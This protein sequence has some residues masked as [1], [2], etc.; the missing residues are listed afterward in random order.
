MAWWSWGTWPD[1]QVDF[2]R[3]LY[4]PWRLAEGDV[5][6]R[7]VAWFNGPLSVYCNAFLFRLFGAGLDTL[8]F[9]NLALLA[10]GVWL[11]HRLVARIAD[12]TTATL[13]CLVALLVFAFNQLSGISNYN[14]VTPYSHE[15]THGVLLGLGTLAALAAFER[16]AGV[17][18]SAATG[19]LAGLTLLTKPEIAAA[20]ALSVAAGWLFLPGP[21]RR[22]G[23]PW[24][25]LGAA[26]PPLAALAL[27][28]LALPPGAALAGLLEGWRGVLAGEAPDLLFYRQLAGFDA[29][30]QRLGSM[31][32]TAL[33]ALGVLLPAA[34]LDLLLRR[35][36]A[37]ST[38]A[39]LLV[40]VGTLAAVG[41]LPVDWL[42][43]LGPLPLVLAALLCGFAWLRF[44]RGESAPPAAARAAFTALG[45]A[46][47]AKLLLTAWA[48]GYGFALALPG[49]AVLLVA[50]FWLAPRAL[51]RYGGSGRVFRAA[52]LALLCLW[53][54]AHLLESHRWLAAN[55]VRVADGRDAF[56]SDWRGEYANAVI[57]A[58]AEHFPA[59]A[60]LVVLPE[61]VMLNYLT[62]RANPTPYLNFM[63][64]EL[65]LFGEAEIIAALDANPPD[66]VILWHKDTREY[67][68]PLFGR[69]Y[70]RALYAWVAARYQPIGTFGAI[71]LRDPDVY[72]MQLLGPRSPATPEG[73]PAPGRVR[74]AF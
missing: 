13:C 21:R 15:V 60:T 48:L 63:P 35:G 72:G 59:D 71:P 51:Q 41:P 66:A 62:R 55:E 28:S 1:V 69:D 57:A 6:Y 29:P 5:L 26:L 70:G 37:W 52:A 49:T 8:V 46:L 7:D 20:V 32:S 43:A 31:G 53:L 19:L 73:D 50:L 18:W 38:P 12:S 74:S 54:A 9:A 36:P 14:F 40:F 16:G 2:G 65:V 33:G 58:L 67:G 39:A 45:L 23:G 11:L 25:L 56:L 61:G 64:P 44:A 68:F 30:L 22:A 34:A 24:L 47:L 27:L 3:E 42:S 10:L 4:A 17:G